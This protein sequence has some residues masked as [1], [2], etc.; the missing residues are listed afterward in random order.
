MPK[1]SDHGPS[2][3]D[4]KL[5]EELREDGASKEKAARIANAK[6]GGENVSK[7]GGESEDYEDRTVEELQDRAAEIGIEG[8]SDM[9]KKELISALRN[10]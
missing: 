8:R 10:H 7:K 2:V 9:N 3:K 6:A 5:Y 4:D 1:G